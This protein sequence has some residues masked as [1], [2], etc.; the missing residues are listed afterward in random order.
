[1]G[2]TQT[3]RQPDMNEV[4]SNMKMKAKM[5]QRESLKC[6]KDKKAFID[7]AKKYLQQGNQ[8][9]ARLNLESANTKSVEAMKYMTIANRLE[10]LSAKVGSNYKTQDVLAFHPAHEPPRQHHSIPGRSGGQ[11]ATRRDVQEDD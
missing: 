5:F 1:M 8:E 4:L 10:A 2:G 6:E 7:K 9:G 11:D 3:K